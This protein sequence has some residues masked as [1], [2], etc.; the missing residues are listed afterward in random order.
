L[1]GAFVPGVLDNSTQ[2]IDDV[3][4]Q[5]NWTAEIVI[6]YFWAGYYC[7]SCYIQKPGHLSRRL[8]ATV[9]DAYPYTLNVSG[10][11]SID[12]LIRL[13]ETGGVEKLDSEDRT[14]AKEGVLYNISLGEGV[15][16]MLENGGQI[17]TEGLTP[18]KPVNASQSVWYGVFWDMD[19][20]N[21][22]TLRL[23]PNGEVSDVTDISAPLLAAMRVTL[24]SE[25]QEQNTSSSGSSMES[26]SGTDSGDN[27]DGA[28]GNE[29]SAVHASKLA[30]LAA[31]SAVVFSA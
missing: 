27:G 13:N 31:L 1:G 20:D 22:V 15:K 24:E 19:S 23:G 9:E 18:N 5:G 30:L 14:H 6:P 21:N 29:G 26:S 28:T 25:G 17:S 3:M 16:V 8:L 2:S 10:S 12:Y 11:D 7:K 4:T